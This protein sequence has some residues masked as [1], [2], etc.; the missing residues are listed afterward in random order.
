VCV[1][2][3]EK[4]AA[5]H[6]G[7]SGL[8]LTFQESRDAFGGEG[9]KPLAVVRGGR[10]DGEVVFIS[11]QPDTLQGKRRP[12]ATGVDLSRHLAQFRP[13]ERGAI[14]RRIR[15]ALEED[16]E[17]ADAVGHI[18]SSVRRSGELQRSLHLTDGGRFEVLP[19]PDERS[20]VYAFGQSRT[21]A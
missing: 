20:V 19:N 9:T 4:T 3:L 6:I 14:E 11:D 21:G 10:Y 5:L 16:D 7:M 15:R 17:P 1:A 2:L 18:V 13:R 12:R 8:R